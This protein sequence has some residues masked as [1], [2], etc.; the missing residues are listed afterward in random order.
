MTAWEV[1]TAQ[2][3][4]LA[5]PSRLQATCISTSAAC[6]GLPGQEPWIGSGW[7]SQGA[8][9]WSPFPLNPS[10]EGMGFRTW[11]PCEG[12]EAGFPGS[13]LPS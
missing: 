2:C 11:R 6:T 1:E 3:H 10:R 13:L 4:P 9:K 5:S 8:L 12:C 7:A